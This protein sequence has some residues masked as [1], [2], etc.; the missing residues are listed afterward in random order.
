MKQRGKPFFL[1]CNFRRNPI[2]LV[3]KIRRDTS[4]AMLWHL[5]QYDLLSLVHVGELEFCE[6]CTASKMHE[7]IVPKKTDIRASAV[8]QR[9]FSDIQ[10]PFETP[11][12]HGARYTLIFIDDLS[13]LAV[14]KYLVKKGNALLKFQ[15]FVAE[16]G[17]QECLRTD[18]GGE[19]SSNAF[20]RFDRESQVRHEFIVPNTHQQ[21]SEAERYNRVSAGSKQN[22]QRFSGCEHC[23]QL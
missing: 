11:S 19:C 3:T 1:E 6:V 9:V 4:D 23:R 22:Y 15:K 7:V 13:R 21:N 14:V 10:G 12:M 8:G 18:N 16:H 2:I 20:R 5:N 17:A